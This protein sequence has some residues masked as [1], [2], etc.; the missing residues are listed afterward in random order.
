LKPAACAHHTVDIE[1]IRVSRDSTE[2]PRLEVLCPRCSRACQQAIR[3]VADAPTDDIS[4]VHKGLGREP[5][6]PRQQRSFL[7]KLGWGWP[8]VSDL[9]E[10]AYASRAA[11]EPDHGMRM[12]SFQLGIICNLHAAGSPT[13]KQRRRR[14]RRRRKG[15][16]RRI[17]D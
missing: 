14:R 17:R 5:R 1:L 10:E 2:A 11:A 15:Q 12:R 4:F 7:V 9:S 3:R 6:I 8:P 16:K 13:T